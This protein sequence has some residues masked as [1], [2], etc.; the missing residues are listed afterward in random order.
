MAEAAAT[1]L[2]RPA[3]KAGPTGLWVA[4]PLLILAVIF[5]YPLSLIVRQSLGDSGVLSLQHFQEVLSSR[6]FLDG[7]YYTIVIAVS[8]TIGCLVLG[9]VLS[10]TIAFVPFP[11]AK[12]AAR[13]ID[14]IIAFPTFLV[15]LAFTF[16]YG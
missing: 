8:A 10:L 5:F 1:A 15:T 2:A 4:P 6:Q 3:P 14:T 13:L 9:F 12:M 11:G 7:L 16:I